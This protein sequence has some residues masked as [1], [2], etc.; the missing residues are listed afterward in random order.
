MEQQENRPSIYVRN[1]NANI[2]RRFIS[3]IFCTEM[4]KNLHKMLC[5]FG[6]KRAIDRFWRND[7]MRFSDASVLILKVRCSITRRFISAVS[8]GPLTYLRVHA[9]M[10]KKSFFVLRLGLKKFG[11]VCA[12]FGFTVIGHMK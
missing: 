8:S 10:F 11:F 7:Q 6:F 5:I 9:L 4:R 1:S 2:T 12:I 3:A